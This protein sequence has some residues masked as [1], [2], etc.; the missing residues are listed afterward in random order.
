MKRGIKFLIAIGACSLAISGLAAC[1]PHD[2]HT[3]GE[4]T[5]EREATC[6][7]DGAKYRV[8]SCGDRDKA[9]IEKLGHD[10]VVDEETPA[11]C[12]TA[13]R[14]AGT[15]CARCGE[16]V[17]GRAEIAQLAH[18][19]GEWTV[20][21]VPTKTAVGS[22]R[23]TCSLGNHTDEVELPVITDTAVWT[24]TKTD[25]VTTYESEYMNFKMVEP[26]V[27][28]ADFIAGLDDEYV[29]GDEVKFRL[30]VDTNLYAV[31]VTVD[32]QEIQPTG[33]N[34]VTTATEELSIN[35]KTS[36]K[37]LNYASDPNTVKETDVLGN[38]HAVTV[39][40]GGWAFG[41]FKFDS[42]ENWYVKVDWSRA[43][44]AKMNV[45][46]AAFKSHASPMGT[47]AYAFN[48][49]N[50]NNNYNLLMKNY[51]AD[52]AWNFNNQEHSWWN[53]ETMHHASIP[54]STSLKL[55]M[56]VLG[57]SYYFYVNGRYVASKSFASV[58]NTIP[59]FI[60]GG[61]GDTTAITFKNIEYTSNLDEV[62]A[63]FNSL[64]PTMMRGFVGTGGT[65]NTAHTAMVNFNNATNDTAPTYTEQDGLKIVY[66]NN[67]GKWAEDKM[68]DY[69]ILSGDFLM[70]FDYTPSSI[71]TADSGNSAALRF[72]FVNS[73]NFG[74][75]A[76]L[77]QINF[78]SNWA[79]NVESTANK[80]GFRVF[81]DTKDNALDWSDIS[82]YGVHVYIKRE[83]VEGKAKWTFVYTSH[84]DNTVARTETVENDMTYDGIIYLR[85]V[86]IA[87]TYSNMKIGTL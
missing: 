70:E 26:T 2:Y 49:S 43:V 62:T 3:Y 69:Q 66:N 28:G 77:G 39:T 22:A 31:L 34:Y 53:V 67:Q 71:S 83:I 74:N 48:L 16:T 81:N 65:I 45:S 86:N 57:R 46:L 20:T 5:V 4:W 15:H 36:R 33:N 80:L 30:N 56:I 82:D 79:Q 37:W 47:G 17:S 64:S 75:E 55:E 87:G 29:V 21:K 38:D 51:G 24:I 63:K 59:G 7:E 58:Q 14:E 85:N 61:C 52:N 41:T 13:G 76:I 54:S 8:C 60:T 11:T 68:S 9:V 32:G 44:A 18:N 23:H 78:N 35:V 40:N 72:D 50:N 27:S 73:T 6:T 84:K 12:Q 1:S 19:Y 42:A 25:K 10:I